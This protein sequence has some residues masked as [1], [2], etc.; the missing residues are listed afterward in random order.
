MLKLAREL[1]IRIPDD[2]ALAGGDDIELAEFLEVPLTTFRQPAREIGMR[3]TESLIARLRLGSQALQQL[4][5]K[6]KLIVRRSSGW[7]LPS[8]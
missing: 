1:R 5:F 2:L 7:K 6:P 4:V 3:G 8:G